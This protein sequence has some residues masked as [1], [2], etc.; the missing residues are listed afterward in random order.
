MATAV[1]DPLVRRA[2]EIAAR[3]GADSHLQTL[4]N[5]Y[6]GFSNSGGSDLKG[7]EKDV[8]TF[9][10]HNFWTRTKTNSPLLTKR[11]NKRRRFRCAGLSTGTVR[12]TFFGIFRFQTDTYRVETGVSP[13][14]SSV[15]GHDLTEYDT[16]LIY[17]PAQW[18]LRKG[19]K[20]GMSLHFKQ[21]AQQVTRSL[22]TFR[23]VPDDSLI[24]E[25]CARG[26]ID[27]IQSLFKRGRA[28]PWDIDSRAWTPL[29]VRRFLTAFC[30][31]CP[32]PC[33]THLS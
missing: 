5:L 4:S 20:L 22:R 33:L 14:F 11:S 2:V 8:D 6:T 16:T 29:H 17:H 32:N 9:E 1:N 25:F 26:N 19:F 13:P 28:S 24:F 15:H 31:W 27:G 30:R 18:L 21:T 3:A 23:P 12:S 10:A 7:L